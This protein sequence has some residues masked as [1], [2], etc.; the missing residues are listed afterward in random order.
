MRASPARPHSRTPGLSG[1]HA[2]ASVPRSNAYVRQKGIRA[3]APV[4]LPPYVQTHVVFF[5][6]EPRFRASAETRR[7]GD[8]HIVRFASLPPLRIARGA[9]RGTP[10]VCTSRLRGALG[11]KIL[12]KKNL[13]KKGGIVLGGRRQGKVDGRG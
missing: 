9:P 1:L 7:A 10:D 13:K 8:A 6:H 5:G 12:F 2:K 3:P 11:G 4:F